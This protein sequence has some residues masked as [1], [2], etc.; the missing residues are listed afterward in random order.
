MDSQPDIKSWE[1]FRSL[2]AAFEADIRMA[3]VVG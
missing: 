1:V 2:D 3:T